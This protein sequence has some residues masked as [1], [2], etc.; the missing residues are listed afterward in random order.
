M[1][2]ITVI[3]GLEL[4]EVES[5]PNSYAGIN[6]ARILPDLANLPSRKTV[7][8]C[9][10]TSTIGMGRELFLLHC[11]ASQIPDAGCQLPAA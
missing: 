5:N 7:P 11:V 10:A 8:I 3:L 1:L 6:T 9:T 2:K 4:F